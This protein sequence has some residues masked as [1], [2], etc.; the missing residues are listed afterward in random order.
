MVVISMVVIRLY[1][2][3]YSNSSYIMVV[4]PMVVIKVY[5]GSYVNGSYQVISW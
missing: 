5:H 3:S 4:I 2:G 1:H